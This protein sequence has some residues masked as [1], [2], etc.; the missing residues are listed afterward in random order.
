MN[1]LYHTLG[2]NKHRKDGIAKVTGREVY[3]S[4]VIL[5]RMWHARVLRSP[6]AHA[7]I[8]SI[9]TTDAQALGAV[10]LTFADVPHLKYNERIVST[11]PF[12][13]RD[14]TVLADK[15]R[16]VGEAIAAVAA[17]T[18]RL[19]EKALRA[20]KVDWEILPHYTDPESAQATGAEPIYESVLL[21]GEQKPIEN[22]VAVSRVVNVGDVEQGFADADH[23]F[24]REFLTSRIYHA[25]M[26]TKSCV[27]D[28]APDGSITV[29]PTTQSIHNVRQLLGEI[30][31]I[32]LHKVNVKRVA[33]G[34]TFGS[35]IQMNSIIPICVAL[36]LK[37][38]R[39]VKLV[40]TREEDM[41][42]H[43]RY[44]TQLK[45]KIG[46]TSD[47][48]I[49]AGHIQAVA[50]IGGHNIQA[51]PLLSVL[52]GWSASLYKFPHL[53]FEGRAVYTNKTPACAMQG[54]GNPQATFAL[55]SLMDEIAHEL[56]ID[57]IDFKLKNY[58]GL[59][60]TF[61][62]QGP[63]VQSIIRSDGVPQLL[64]E[65]AAKIGWRARPKPG[66][67]TGR[68]RHGIGMARGFHTSGAGA[69]KPG[70]VIDYS[71]AFVKV[72]EDGSVDVVHAMMDHGGGTLEAIAKIVAEELGV[73]V[74]KVGIAP[75]D[76]LTTVYDVVTHAT[77]GVYAGGGAALKAARNVKQQIFENASRILGLQADSFVIEPDYELMQGVIY[78]PNF[79]ERRITL[80][81]L[82]KQLQMNSWGTMAAVESL[83]QVNCP[84]AFVTYFVDVTVDTETGQVTTNR[85][86]MG[87][88]CGTLINPN[89]AI[90]QLEGGLSKGVGYALIEDNQWDAQTGQL[91]SKGFWIDGKT[92]AISEAP[93]NANIITH[94][95]DTYE[96]SG[97]F[98]AKGIGEAATNPCAAAY[99]NA[100][101]NALGIRFTELPITPEKI[102]C[103][104]YTEQER[105]TRERVNG[106]REGVAVMQ[107][108]G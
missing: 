72:N 77:R 1:E 28:P 103:A 51:Y 106:E 33:I 97:P 3:A 24:E 104:I 66:A 12:L 16:H 30:F 74:E 8:K 20:L 55:E 62:G 86:V 23:V 58:V 44:Q 45:V 13:Y 22:N 76:T 48:K 18:E 57:P 7:R 84:P 88:D 90:G 25:Q 102:L 94:F 4:D 38:G 47:G 71:G 93:T 41:Y 95:S 75:A 2:V 67:Q 14:R 70:E 69:P 83:R 92:P 54:F 108:A 37:A 63:S 101:Y 64:R 91:A 26:E 10:T 52:A 60:G 21:N 85:A 50:D 65:G 11:P 32:P 81:A 98:G 99:A 46:V 6:Y 39:P 68:Y 29:Y 87:S 53:R 100:L 49:T 17:P 34:G 80:G 35:S 107:T 56:E 27:C 40:S 5:P 105:E 19:A 82:A 9:D 89:M 73:P 36:A 78:C 61:W 59:G 96:P 42:D 15:A 79:P 31:E 43:T